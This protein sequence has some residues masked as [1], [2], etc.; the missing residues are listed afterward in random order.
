MTP[1]II[2]IPEIKEAAAKVM[3]DEE[4]VTAQ[5]NVLLMDAGTRDFANTEHLK[6]PFNLMAIFTIAMQTGYA[7]S[8]N[9]KGEQGK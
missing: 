1:P 6:G 9:R 7:L 8:E 5:L 2:S 3:A 4:A